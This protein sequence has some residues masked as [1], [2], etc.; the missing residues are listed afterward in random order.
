MMISNIIV[1]KEHVVIKI[2]NGETYRLNYDVYTDL[3]LYNGKDISKKEYQLIR[4]LSNLNKL[5]KWSQNYLKRYHKSTYEYK[6]KLKNKEVSYQNIKYLVYRM[7]EAGLLNDEKYAAS[8]KEYYE[9][10]NYGRNYIINKLFKAGISYKYISQ[11][12]F[13]EK[14]EIEKINNLKV[15]INENYDDRNEINKIYLLLLRRGFDDTL[16][17]KII[18]EKTKIEFSFSL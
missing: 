11:L 5:I 8:V 18:N 7:T 3:F 6:N 16:I 17:K 15:L 4:N 10:K 9:F 2:E 14:S 12:Q 13:D 1:K